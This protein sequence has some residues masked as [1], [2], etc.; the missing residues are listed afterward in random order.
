LTYIG[1][2]IDLVGI[3]NTVE[4]NGTNILQN[5]FFCVQTEVS[6]TGLKQPEGE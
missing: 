4:V 1:T 2:Y 5:I 6:H 3:K